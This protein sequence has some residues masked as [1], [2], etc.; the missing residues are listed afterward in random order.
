MADGFT[1]KTIALQKS[2]V[3]MKRPTLQH[4]VVTCIVGLFALVPLLA[5]ISGQGSYVTLFSRIMIYALAALG[6]GLVLGYGALVSLGH[7]MY[8]GIG[9][10]AVGMLSANGITNG[11]AHLGVSLAVGLPVAIIVGLICLRASGVAFI[12]ITLA[13]AQMFYYFAIGLRTYGGDDGLQIA[14]RSNFGVLDISNNTVFYY[15]IFAVLMLTL[16]VLHRMVG[17]RFGML[18]RGTKSNQRRMAALGFPVMRYKLLAYVISA[19][20]CV[21]AGVLLGNLVRFASPA[22]MQWSVSG[23]LIV[24]V[25]LGGLGTLIGPVIGA[26]VWLLLEELLTQV[27]FGLP[28]GMDDMIRDHWFLVL[29]LFVLFVSLRLK[30]GIYGWVLERQQERKE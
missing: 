18:L 9:A 13:F 16:Y 1:M 29:G 7:A 30:Q 3:G 14:A 12:M 17:S 23:E 21:V 4:A 26:S 2:A 10:Y 15:V 25:V 27:K 20:I 24:M 11:F 5:A 6:L 28:W 19:L 22:Y 8:L